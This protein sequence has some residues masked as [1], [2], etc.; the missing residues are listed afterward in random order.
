MATD[1]ELQMDRM[2]LSESGLV[3]KMI[4]KLRISYDKYNPTRGGKFLAL[5]RWISLKH[6]SINIQNKDDKCF[7]YSV[8]CGIYRVYEKD[9]PERVS[10][11][12]K[13]TDTL[14]WD[15]VNFPS[16]N[17]DIDTFEENNEGKVAVNVYFIDLEE[18]KE[19]ILL[20]RKTKVLKAER[21]VETGRW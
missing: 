8:Q 2:E 7:K 11:Y 17:V 16:S 13:L 19:S 6:A 1:I 21:H 15:N 3:V 14:N 10:H 20:Y 5:P 4:E 18:G 9:H 12:N